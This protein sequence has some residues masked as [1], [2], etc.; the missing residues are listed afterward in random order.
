MGNPSVVASWGQAVLCRLSPFLPPPQPA[1]AC[2]AICAHGSDP[3]S[4]GWLPCDGGPPGKVSLWRR[5]HECTA[6][7]GRRVHPGARLCFAPAWRPGV[8]PPSSRAFLGAW[9]VTTGYAGG[10][11]LGALFAGR[12]SCADLD[13][14]YTEGTASLEWRYLGGI[15]QRGRIM[16]TAMICLNTNMVNCGGQKRQPS[17]GVRSHVG[18]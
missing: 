13:S 18:G 11:S 14:H 17:G 12:I 7:G 6:R 15:L 9:S 2:G 5:G 3:S 16:A 1:T 10:Q 8:S 4:G